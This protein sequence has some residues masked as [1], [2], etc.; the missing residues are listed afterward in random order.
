MFFFKFLHSFKNTYIIL[1]PI[2]LRKSAANYFRAFGYKNEFHRINP[3]KCLIRNLFYL[4]FLIKQTEMS[5][6]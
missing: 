4:T 5:I 3:D 1:F 2:S 6:Q